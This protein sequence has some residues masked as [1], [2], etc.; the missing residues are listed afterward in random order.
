MWSRVCLPDGPRRMKRSFSFFGL[1]AGG[2]ILSAPMVRG[3]APSQ[4]GTEFFESKIRPILANNC[5]KCHSSQAAKLKGGLSVE[6]RESLLKGGDDGPA[7]VPGDPE[8]SLLI[9]AVRYQDTD[10]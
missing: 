6:Y 9:K 5:Y 7:V 10:L 2:I 8:K 3:Q 4:A 1:I